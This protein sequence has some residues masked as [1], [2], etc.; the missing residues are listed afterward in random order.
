MMSLIKD[1]RLIDD[2]FIN[3]TDRAQISADGPVIVSLEQWQNKRTELLRR[4]GTLGIQLGSDQH[5]EVIAE[6]LDH[7]QLVALEFPAFR[8]GRAYSYA[9][10]L[11][12]RYGFSGELR[13]V[14]DVLLDQLHF[15][16]RVGINAF[17]IDSDDPL[18]DFQST[19]ANFSVWYQPS[20]DQRV[21]A[22]A[23]RHR[24]TDS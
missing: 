19:M 18:G 22:V 12:G 5:P 11:R 7:F 9:R 16:D 8:D 6:D 24:S 15:M 20:G 2:Q 13:A 1:G 17:E 3:V 4:G 21:T 23:L 10:L 14:G